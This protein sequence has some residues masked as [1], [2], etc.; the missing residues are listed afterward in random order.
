MTDTPRQPPQHHRPDDGNT[1]V[2]LGSKYTGT[3]PVASAATPEWYEKPTAEQH[4]R[5]R[6]RWLGISGTIVTVFS[7]GIALVW[8]TGF[9]EDMPLVLL[10]P[11]LTIGLSAIL[12]SVLEY[13]GR[14]SRHAQRRCIERVDELEVCLL[15]LVALMGEELQR[16][17]YQGA[18]WN[19]RLGTQATGTEN[20]RRLRRPDL[21]GGNTGEVVEFSRPSPRPRP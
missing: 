4:I 2:D 20:A 9:G 18:A 8:E 19:A 3:A 1:T 17:F 12:L 10:L 6:G 16:K 14:P 7:T 13:F 21:G 15:D 11:L 5:T